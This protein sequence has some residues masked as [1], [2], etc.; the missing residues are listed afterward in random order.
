MPD[1]KGYVDAT[2]LDT[3]KETVRDEK[4]RSYILLELAT[5]S[6]VLEVGCGPATDTLALA[7]LV[8]ASG[9]VVGI[10]FDPDMIALAQDRARSAGMDGRVSHQVADATSLPF[11]DDTFD[12]CRSERLFQ[13]LPDPA[14]A[15]G[16]MVRV[17]KPGGRIVVFD[18]D[19]ETVAVDLPDPDLWRRL[20]RVRVDHMLTNARSGR[21]LFRLFREAGLRDVMAEPRAMASLD[22]GFAQVAGSLDEVEIKAVELGVVSR[23]EMDHMRSWSEH[24]SANGTFFFCWTMILASGTKA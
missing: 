13:H 12:A 1:F 2:Y 24:A 19:H 22:Y 20:Q 6:S 10:D 11:P 18:T 7:D 21:Q 23:E 17:T 4:E 8:G 16:E 5:G 9:R 3:L 14:A 15:L